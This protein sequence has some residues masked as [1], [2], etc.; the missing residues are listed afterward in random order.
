MDTTFYYPF[1]KYP[2]ISNAT[3]TGYRDPNPCPTEFLPADMHCHLYPQP[4]G[5]AFSSSLHAGGN[6]ISFSFI[7]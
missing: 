2:W 4:G 1:Y 3:H 7:F 6:L 5:V